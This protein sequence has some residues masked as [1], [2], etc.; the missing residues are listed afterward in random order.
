[1]TYWSGLQ[2]FSGSHD[3]LVHMTWSPTPAALRLL[4]KSVTTVAFG[5]L[6]GLGARDE[7]YFVAQYRPCALDVYA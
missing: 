3:F 6:S 2:D 5:H 7:D 4:A 1:V